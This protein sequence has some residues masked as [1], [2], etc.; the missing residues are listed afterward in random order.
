MK[1]ENQ[2]NEQGSNWKW[3]VIAFLLQLLGVLVYFAFLMDLAWGSGWGPDSGRPPGYK[4]EEN[5][6]TFVFLAIDAVS[7]IV[8]IQAFRRAQRANQEIVSVFAA[9]AV[10]ISVMLGCGALALARAH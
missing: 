4:A 5:R 8:A 10:V 1:R 3:T 7:C 2:P 6:G 9:L